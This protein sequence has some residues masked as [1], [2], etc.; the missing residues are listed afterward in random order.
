MRLAITIELIFIIRKHIDVDMYLISLENDGRMIFIVHRRHLRAV[1]TFNNSHLGAIEGQ[2]TSE[3]TQSE[4]YATRES[5]EEQES[6]SGSR[7]PDSITVKETHSDS[8]E[9]QEDD[10]GKESI[11]EL[12]RSERL[13]SKAVNFTKFFDLQNNA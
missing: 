13:K 2:D 8:D 7:Q 11:S 9:L 5:K 6:E 3:K 12:R 10:S 4:S 1:A